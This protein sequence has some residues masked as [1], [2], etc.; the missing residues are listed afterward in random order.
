LSALEI[1]AVVLAGVGAGAVNSIV[2]SG[3]LLTF[4][5][6]LVIGYS[7]VVANASNT[8]GVVPGAMFGA[9]GYRAELTGQRRFV[10]R[11]AVASVLGGIAGALLFLSLPSGVFK[12][13]VPIL[14]G[15]ACLLV[16]VQ[17]RIAAFL[18]DR[19]ASRPAG[20]ISP[21]LFAATFLVGVYG[22]YFGGGQGIM[23]LA[24]LGLFL[25]ESLQRV[26]GTKNVLA[27]TANTVAAVAFI[28]AGRVAWEPALLI[29]AGSSVGGIAGARFG[30]QL[31]QQA[32]RGLIV[33]V[34]ALT[35]A[36]FL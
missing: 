18:A 34:G 23:L 6:L 26:N 2:G 31:S 29:A 13:V 30:R 10:S 33:V 12:A 32:L 27:A 9:Y 25:R 7:P 17:P 8:L 16:I 22:G 5:V 19:P 14:I 28:I 21:G 11:L 24:V 1:V 3:T 35:I 4:P 36:R 20:T 15:I